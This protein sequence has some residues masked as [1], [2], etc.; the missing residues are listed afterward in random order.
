[1]SVELFLSQAAELRPQFTIPAVARS[2]GHPDEIARS[3]VRVAEEA[4]DE[5]LE[6]QG[7]RGETFSLRSSLIL[8]GA[9]QIRFGGGKQTLPMRMLL[10][11]T[12]P[13]IPDAKK[14]ELEDLARRACSQWVKGHLRFVDWAR[15]LS[16]EL[17]LRCR[18]GARSAYIS[19]ARAPLAASQYFAQE[20]VALGTSGEFRS[21]FPEAGDEIEVSTLGAAGRL[22][23]NVVIPMVD[24]FVHS[25]RSYFLRKKEIET[26]FFEK[27]TSRPAEYDRVEI[28][29]NPEDQPGAG[30]A[31]LLL[32]VL[33]T[34]A[35]SRRP[36]TA[37]GAP[38]GETTSLHAREFARSIV[39][40]IRG[41]RAAVVR[42]EEDDRGEIRKAF[43]RLELLEG[44]VLDSVRAAVNELVPLRTHP[45][46]LTDL[47]FFDTGE[48]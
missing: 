40:R 3:L 19:I 13:Q 11:G 36:G 7:V 17:T 20:I 46:R 18:G 15:D 35:D 47:G 34:T 38:E 29:M 37:D 24:R 25:E 28:V 4:L 1:M 6:R 12:G 48:L 44:V 5:E 42:L 41:V 31:G 2:A 21:L 33:G 26:Y 16:I 14:N 27:L 30:E 22:R 32:T 39:S 23:V 8:P 9:A 45:A 10:V 43:V